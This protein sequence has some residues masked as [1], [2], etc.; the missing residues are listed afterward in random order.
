M[1][2]LLC[3][4]LAVCML[5]AALVLPSAAAP[6]TPP[7]YASAP[8]F[9]VTA[10][11]K[12][13]ATGESITLTAVNAPQAQAGQTV[14]YHWYFYFAPIH[15]NGSRLV[16]TTADAVIQIQAPGRDIV[17]P[18]QANPFSQQFSTKYWCVAEISDAS[19]LVAS[20]GS[21]EI[22]VLGYYS[23]RDSFA[24]PYEYFPSAAVLF[25]VPGVFFQAI[26]CLFGIL[27]SPWVAVANTAEA[28]R[29][30]G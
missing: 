24:V 21:N 11:K 28:K 29:V 25:F 13:V 1:K 20:Y 6:D 19:G 10:D 2:K 26:A 27:W 3:A 12:M 8:A 18:T 7:T 23:L 15:G 4:F 16:G 5:S 22:D 9:A 14:Q 17:R 30:N